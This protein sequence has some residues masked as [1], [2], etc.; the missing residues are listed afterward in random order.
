MDDGCCML[1]NVEQIGL[2]FVVQYYVV[3]VVGLIYCWMNLIFDVFIVSGRIQVNVV[4]EFFVE[5]IDDGRM[6]YINKVIVYLIDVFMSF[7]Q[8]YGVIYEDVVVVCQV[9]GGDYNYC[10]ILLFV[11]SIVWCVFLK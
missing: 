10:E 5:K 1:I 2:G 11:V 6:C 4:W 3:E 9:V 8:D 7:I